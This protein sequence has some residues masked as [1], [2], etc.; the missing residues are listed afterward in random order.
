MTVQRVGGEQRHGVGRGPAHAC[1]RVEDAHL[2][3]GVGAHDAVVPCAD[4]A[5]VLLPSMAAAA[6]SRALRAGW[7][8]DGA[9]R[10]LTLE[11]PPGKRLCTQQR[12]LLRTR[13]LAA[14][15]ATVTTVLL[16]ACHPRSRSPLR[17]LSVE[18]LR[19][20]LQDCIFAVRIV[21]YRACVGRVR[22][23]NLTPS[24]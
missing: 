22:Q 15:H 17:L 16:G 6:F 20:V 8:Q 10:R 11:L 21:E 18:L 3:L 14:P 19:Q 4:A 5:V 13:A 24:R 1:E 7:E 12:L 2:R 9:L 23:V